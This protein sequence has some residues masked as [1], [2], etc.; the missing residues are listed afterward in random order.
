MSDFLEGIEQFLQSFA[1]EEVALTRVV[2]QR[3]LDGHATRPD[4]LAGALGMTP[5]VVAVAVDRLVERGTIA[6]DPETGDVVGARGLSLGETPHRLTLNGR[7]LYAFCAVDAVGIPAALE[8]DARVESRCH[9]CGAA[10]SV[11]L[12]KGIV[13]EA[14]PGVLVWAAERDLTR[15]LHT[16]T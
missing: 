9:G 4:G 3:L 1:P 7:R 12:N 8:A 11:T 5:A 6:V 15:P 2:F 16:Y 13:T 14:P 10:V